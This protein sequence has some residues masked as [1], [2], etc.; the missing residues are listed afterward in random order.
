MEEALGAQHLAAMRGNSQEN[1]ALNLQQHYLFIVDR[2]RQDNVS[3]TND[4]IIEIHER[5]TGF[6][7][8]C[9]AGRHDCCCHYLE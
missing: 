8:F 4:W 5:T 9:S 7:A 2:S 1:L 6:V 3:E